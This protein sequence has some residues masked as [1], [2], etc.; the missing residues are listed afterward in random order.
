MKI[1]ILSLTTLWFGRSLNAPC[2]GF[3]DHFG[4][5]SHEMKNDY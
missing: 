4:V 1:I 2:Y 3:G 5:N